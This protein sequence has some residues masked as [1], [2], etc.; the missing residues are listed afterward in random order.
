MQERATKI[1]E[2]DAIVLLSSEYNSVIPPALT[3][4]LCHFSPSLFTCKPSGIV[5]YSLGVF[6]GM[7]VTMQL[8]ALLGDMGCLSIGNT[9]CI[10]EVNKA[11]DENGI[12]LNDNVVRG[13]AKM[14]SQLDWVTKALKSHKGNFG[15]P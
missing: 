5:T 4:M 2:S 15:L 13:A 11:L 7:R 10:P 12:P 1:K 8:R 14:I 9:F 3:N 6:G